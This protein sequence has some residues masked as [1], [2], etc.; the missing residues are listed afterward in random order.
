MVREDIREFLGR[1]PEEAVDPELA[2]SQGAAI[3]A[4][5]IN[6]EILPENSIVM[7]D[8][9]PY[10][11]G[12]RTFN[13]FSNDCMSVIIRRNSTI[14]SVKKDTFAPSADYQE[15]V[16]VDVYQGESDIASHNH[17]LGTFTVN[18]V[19]PRK[20]GKEKV[21]IEF[22]YDLNGMLKVTA[23]LLSTGKEASIDIDM[24]RSKKKKDKAVN[25][26]KSPIARRFKRSIRE[27]EK[28]LKS[29]ELE[30]LPFEKETIDEMLHELKE[31]VAEGDEERAL[32]LDEELFDLMNDLL[33]DEDEP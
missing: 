6:D 24:L 13:G 9:N 4:G 16:K 30:A 26:E 31:A 21:S 22:S 8:V 3:Q 7:T 28:L 20:A 27:T 11:L 14:P 17:F 23:M 33:E 5:I 1:E 10:S 12:V 32:E 15:S 29:D 19:P 25:W 2:V 18:G